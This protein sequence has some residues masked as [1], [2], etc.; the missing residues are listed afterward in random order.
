MA[1]VRVG[2][3]IAD[4]YEVTKVVGMGGMGIVVAA[5]HRELDK[6]VALKFMHEEVARNEHAIDRFLREAR[7]AARLQNEHVGRVL[8]VGRMHDGVPYIVMEYLEGHDLA[9]VLEQHGA[10]DVS[11]AIAYVLQTCEAMAEAHAQGIIHRDLKPQNL[12]VTVRPDGR[13]L[14]KVLDFGISKALF[15]QAATATHATMG[16][17]AYMSPEQMKSAKSV[18]A[19]ADV[20]SLG[21]ILYQLLSNTLPWHGDTITETMLKV[22]S[23]PLPPLSTV[24][25]GLPVA[26]VATVERCLEKDRDLRFASV[27][28]LARA[29][30]PFAQ[31]HARGAI[32]ARPAAVSPPI[33]HTT[34]GTAAAQSL[35]VEPRRSGRWRWAL[36]SVVALATVISIPLA[37]RGG[38]SASVS[39]S[40]AATPASADASAPDAATPD[41][42]SDATLDAGVDAPSDAPRRK[43]GGGSRYVDAGVPQ[44]DASYQPPKGPD[45]FPIPR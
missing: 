20:W 39:L 32:V 10:L 28:E 22:L 23:D 3:V 27:T 41:A 42:T 45:D 14:L 40:D 8:D 17:P 5:R 38:R 36:V 6:L 24:R 12:F 44:P 7:A 30:E 43:P 4:K 25:P 35:D 19:R 11:N 33:I 37:L 34:L 15:A 18:D 16:S 29:L 31:E 21:V 1:L 9:A 13:P 2:D 26:L